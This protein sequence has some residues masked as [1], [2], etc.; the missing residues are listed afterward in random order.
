MSSDTSPLTTIAPF[1][2]AEIAGIS[3]PLIGRDEELQ[4]LLRQLYSVIEGGDA[5]LVTIVGPAGIG[6]S[7][8]AH[9]FRQVVGRL[10][11]P[12]PL[13][14]L[15]ADRQSTAQPYSLI[16]MLVTTLF[17]I[18]EGDA[19]AAAR[20]R[21]EHGVAT[22]LGSDSEEKAHFI[23]QLAGYDFADSP[24]LRGAL[25]EPRQL[26]DR[27]LHYAAQSL[28]ALTA[29][30]P[31][32][33][34]LDDFHYAD[35]SSIDAVA[36]VVREGRAL[37]MLVV[38]LT[39]QRLYERRPDWGAD[40]GPLSVRID[41]GPL[42]ERTS[43]RLVA[44]I[45]RKA[46]KLPVD[47]RNLLVSKAEG[48]PFYVEELIKMLI[49]DG[50]IV[51]GDAAWTIRQ[52]RLAR[53]RIPATLGEVLRARVQALSPSERE[54]VM[55]AA[56][57]GRFFWAE[58]ALQLDGVAHA[59][60]EVAA[61]ETQGASLL[62]SLEQQELIAPRAESRFVGQREYAFR[63]ELLHE[64]AYEQVPPA[65]RA[66]YH[67][68]VAEWLL[69]HSGERT[70]AFAALIAEHYERAEQRQAAAEWYLRAGNHAR[71]TYALEPALHQ[72]RTAL[73]LL[74]VGAEA[75]PER[76]ACY[77]GIGEVQLWAAR[78]SDAAASYIRM[79]QLAAA[80]GDPVAAARGWNGLA[81]VQDHNL[82][83][84]S[85]KASALQAIALAESAGDTS[86][87]ALG[88][89][90]LAWAELRLNNLQAAHGIGE[91][92]LALLAQADDPATA[93]RWTGLL[94]VIYD[95][96]GDIDRSVY[97][98]HEALR[99]HQG[100]GNLVEV[101]TQFNNLGSTANMRGDFA[102]A[103]G[104]LQ[105]AQLVSSKIGS[106]VMDIFILSNLGITYNG[107][108]EYQAAEETVR[109]GIE[110]SELSRMPVFSEYYC[111]LSNACLGQE[112]VTEAVEAAQQALELA[113]SHEGPREVAAA[114]RALGAAISEM[115]APLGAPPCFEESARLFEASGANGER[116]RTLRAW[117]AHEQR[118]GNQ[119]RSQELLRQ[120][121]TIFEQAGLPLELAR[122][123]M[124]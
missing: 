34:L 118:H 102:A 52:G 33:L 5:R 77:E 76:I 56:V 40:L 24:H 35:D 66:R 7:R 73:A 41:L 86:V 121:R 28:G 122:T 113:R 4:Q 78:L 3:P 107:L 88:L 43:R 11:E 106:R 99:Y 81:F 111:A 117:A 25:A 85:S 47:L 29:Q 96:L 14:T 13:F 8:L 75:D 105:E 39:Q 9:E 17:R 87:L 114:W 120:A 44:E 84:P 112:R 10:H 60:S 69:A 64:V 65:L 15:Q 89:F 21:I 42:D 38:C 32:V 54:F 115:S 123:T 16:R 103:L 12:V 50:V 109:R 98:Q 79:A 100:V 82:E 36:Q 18:R 110:L 22:L 119:A 91:R 97:Y 93:A 116:A 51:P 68:R 95:M 6:K 46:G 63:H 124:I 83:Y 70:G 101:S 90:H 30:M 67:Q 74:P 48:N 49:S 108:G 59:P 26:R 1:V 23:G 55:R 72:Y 53:L 58:A 19:P 2:P 62:A 92:A 80:A 37:G 20:A 31:L 71:E 94:G 104:Y 61:A 57:V 45:L 27:A